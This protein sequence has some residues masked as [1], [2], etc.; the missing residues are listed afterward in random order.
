MDRLVSVT[1]DADQGRHRQVG[2]PPSPR[3]GR[4]RGRGSV[5]ARRL[6]SDPGARRRPLPVSARPESPAAAAPE[7][8]LTIA[9]HF[10]PVNRWL[11][12]AEGESTITPYLLLYA[13]HD[14]LLKPMPGA[15]SAPSLAESWSMASD[16]LSAEF[17]LRQ[18]A[19]FHNGE[20]VTAEDVKFSFERYRGGGAKILKDHVKEI[21]VLG[22]QRLRFVFGSRGPTSRRSTARSWP[23]PAGSCRRSTSSRWARRR[24]AGRPS[25]PAPTS[26][27][28]S[29][30]AWSWCSR[31]SRATG[32]SRR[33]SSGSCS[34]ACRT[35]PRALRRSRAARS[36][37][38]CS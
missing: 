31:R 18:S 19:K 37:S 4:G 12:P 21:Q 24:F 33:R 1:R 15:G 36:T 7:G 34:A 3:R 25:A 16:G 14:G 10:S 6:R 35:R 8:T 5:H 32:A 28:A 9:L 38:R 22:P 30:P 2:R 20:P 13:L 29:S 27:S 23:A 17:V 11:D 26:S